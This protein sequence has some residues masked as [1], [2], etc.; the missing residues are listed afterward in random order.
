[1]TDKDF[2]IKEFSMLGTNNIRPAIKDS[3][4]AGRLEIICG[5][6]FSGKSEELIRRIRRAVIA[7]QSVM[8]FKHSLDDRFSFDCVSSHAGDKIDAQAI[9]KPER[10]LEYTEKVP[11]NVIGIDEVQFFSNNI[12]YVI[13]ELVNQGKRVI[14]AGLDLDFK[15]VPF[16]PMPLLL[17]LAY[18]V[19]KLKAICAVCGKDAAFSQRLINGK[20]AKYTDP[21]ILI[22]ADESYQA[23][24]K[25]CYT[26]DQVPTSKQKFH[27][28]SQ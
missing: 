19:I 4:T 23:R 12:I 25:N 8:T 16:G 17:T 1:M 9:D 15:G 22:G 11:V 10:I 13:D 20:P 27:W 2:I 3:E 5:P 14:A 18:D 7:R 24:C 21:I 28:L 26:I 6:M